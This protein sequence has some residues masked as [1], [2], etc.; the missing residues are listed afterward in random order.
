ML[1]RGRMQR[2]QVTVAP[3]PLCQD[4]GWRWK[5]ISVVLG[6]VT[7]STQKEVNTLF[8]KLAMEK[9]WQCDENRNH[10][11]QEEEREKKVLGMGQ[12]AYH[13]HLTCAK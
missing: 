9:R 5:C 3:G 2:Y 10:T 13:R 4:W 7:A 12:A 1:L 8:P 6:L 11:N